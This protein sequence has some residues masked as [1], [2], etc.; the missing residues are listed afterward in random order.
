MKVIDTQTHG[1]W[2]GKKGNMNLLYAGSPDD[3]KI[4]HELLISHMSDQD[5]TLGLF[6]CFSRLLAGSW[7]RN[8]EAEI[9]IYTHMG[10]PVLQMV[11]LP[12]IP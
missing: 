2:R 12:A 7:I 3:Y 10:M 8:I 5:Q 6:C 11:A 9:E 1:G 4:G